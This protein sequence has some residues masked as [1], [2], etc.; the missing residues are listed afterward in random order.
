MPLTKLTVRLRRFRT[1]AL[2]VELHHADLAAR[3]DLDI[4]N[5]EHGRTFDR[6]RACAGQLDRHALR[7]RV[8]DDRGDLER[9]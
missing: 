1:C 2:G 8:Q 4:G 6:A 5:L 9:R 7:S 3:R